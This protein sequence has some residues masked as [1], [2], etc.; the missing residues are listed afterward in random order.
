MSIAE[1]PKTTDRVRALYEKFPYPLRDPE[2][3]RRRIYATPLD[4]LGALNFYCYRGRRDFR[5]GFRA[6]VAGGG[7][8]DAVTHLAE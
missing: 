5:Q 1:F 4:N 7:T 3:E 2:D 6:L 8:G